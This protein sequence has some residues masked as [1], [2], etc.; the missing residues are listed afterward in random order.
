[1]IQIWQGFL[2]S[3]N[4]FFN[5]DHTVEGEEICARV[6]QRK[7]KVI[8]A[9]ENLTMLDPVTREEKLTLQ[10]MAAEMPD[11]VEDFIKVNNR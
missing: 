3:H 4:L 10:E 1:M 6:L 9:I 2:N 7:N 5:I 8:D 11:L